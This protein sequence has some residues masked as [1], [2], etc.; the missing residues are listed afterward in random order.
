MR[1]N[2]PKDTSES[3]APFNIREL[4]T[5]SP[6]DKERFS[7]FLREED[8]A[9]TPSLSSRMDLDVY[10][11]RV[12]KFGRVIAAF[13]G[14]EIVGLVAFYNNDNETWIGAFTLL[15]VK[16]K[17][18]R[19]GLGRFLF[20]EGIQEMKRAGMKRI[21][22]Q[23]SSENPAVAM[24]RQ[25][26]FEVMYPAPKPLTSPWIILELKF[27]DGIADGIKEGDS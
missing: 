11:D 27:S 17:F 12:M 20:S 16:K 3:V 19:R 18:K 13:D 6:A 4:G 2:D 10:S 9:F 15:A 14:D 25:F 1:N 24:Y 7:R 23:T 8:E 22:F 26:G 5:N 21:R